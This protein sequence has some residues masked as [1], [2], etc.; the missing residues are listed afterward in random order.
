M[1]ACDPGHEKPT[2]Q[3]LVA[4]FPLF[5]TVNPSWKPPDHEFVR[6][7]ATEH[8][9]AEPVLGVP[10]G[11]AVGLVLGVAVAVGLVVGLAVAVALVLG[12]G[13]ALALAV[14]GVSVTTVTEYGLIVWV[15]ALPLVLFVINDPG[16]A[17]VETAGALRLGLNPA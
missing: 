6:D 3:E 7:Q 13:L 2:V 17:R 12:L 15:E 5:V 14:F 4:D 16:S 11:V 8:D 10:V 1:I 9:F